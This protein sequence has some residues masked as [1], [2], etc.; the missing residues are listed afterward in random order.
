MHFE[1]DILAK[2]V[3]RRAGL[4]IL[5]AVGLGLATGSCASSGSTDAPD[6]PPSETS[7]APSSQPDEARGYTDGAR[8]EHLVAKTA[9]LEARTEAVQL[10]I[11]LQRYFLADERHEFPDALDDLTEGDR[12]LIEDRDLLI[13]P[14]GHR[15]IYRRDG[16]REF[17]VFSPG[18]DG[19]PGTEDDVHP[20]ED[21]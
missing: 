4:S 5:L 10:K 6:S 18:P 7:T 16:D 20:S 12:P 1:S 9:R 15:Y 14:W 19:E 21:R 17:E 2:E 3:A 13:D 8:V 11:V